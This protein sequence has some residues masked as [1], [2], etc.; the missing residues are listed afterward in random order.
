MTDVST[1]F[2]TVVTGVTVY[3]IGKLIETTIVKSVAKQRKIISLIAERLVYNANL[4][5]NPGSADKVELKSA[6]Q[7]YRELSGLL[8]ATSSNIPF[9]WIVAKIPKTRASNIN[10]AAA[11]LMFLSNGPYT[12]EHY[13][14]K[15]TYDTEELIKRHLK[16]HHFSKQT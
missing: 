16:L 7:E 5:H 2:W 14:A 11:H 6:Y 3:V 1:I 8:R 4:I 9:Y 10:K 15:D 12:I 13:N